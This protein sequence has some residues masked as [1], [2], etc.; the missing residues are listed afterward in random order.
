MI[1]SVYPPITPPPPHA[2]KTRDDHINHSPVNQ[3]CSAP[4]QSSRRASLDHHPGPL[5]SPNLFLTNRRG[6]KKE[7]K[8]EEPNI[9]IAAQPWPGSLAGRSVNSLRQELSR[10]ITAITAAKKTKA[11]TH[12]RNVHPQAYTQTHD[13][14]PE[15]TPEQCVISLLGDL[16]YR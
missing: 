4:R 15:K 12:Y 11:A 10:L 5:L 14:G 2:I 7:K 3:S 6:Y 9:S 1:L 13:H 8:K 16:H